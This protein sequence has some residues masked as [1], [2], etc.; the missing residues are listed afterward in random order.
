[1]SWALLH[2][3]MI[4]PSVEVLVAALRREVERLG[5]Q[6]LLIGSGF[7]VEAARCAE[8]FVADL[9]IAFEERGMYTSVS[10]E[11]HKA[12]HIIAVIFSRL[13]YAARRCEPPLATWRGQA[14]RLDQELLARR[15]AGSRR[16]KS[17]T[18]EC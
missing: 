9:A 5:L 16:A 17:V 15:H 13:G 10:T 18:T 11:G 12:Y 1:M 4:P 6:T 2:H 7:W 3:A 14:A 8:R